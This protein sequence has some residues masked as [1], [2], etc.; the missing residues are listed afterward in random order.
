MHAELRVLCHLESIFFRAG[1]FN[2]ISEKESTSGAVSGRPREGTDWKQD[3]FSGPGLTCKWARRLRPVGGHGCWVMGQ[4]LPLLGKVS[5]VNIC[6]LHCFTFT[7]Q[8]L[9]EKITHTGTNL[10]GWLQN[11]VMVYLCHLYNIF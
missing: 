10:L 4:S 7:I 2:N 3:P 9:T 11:S 1:V 8:C 5:P 6:F